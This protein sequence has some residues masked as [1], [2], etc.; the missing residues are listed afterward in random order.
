MIEKHN[1]NLGDLE[2][3]VE[4]GAQRFFVEFTIDF[5]RVDC[6]I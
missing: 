3:H 2:L 4:F 1:R 6:R 5:W